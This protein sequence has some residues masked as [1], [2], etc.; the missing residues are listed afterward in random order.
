M[1]YIEPY[2]TVYQISKHIRCNLSG[3]CGVFAS[4]CSRVLLKRG[5]D[6]FTV[7]FGWVKDKEGKT[8]DHIWLEVNGEELDPTIVQFGRNVQY[9]KQRKHY[10]PKNFLR[11][12]G[13][14]L[15]EEKT[16]PWYRSYIN[17]RMDGEVPS[18]NRTGH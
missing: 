1:K 17:T 8:F 14:S 5:F 12:S 18:L 7:V 11:K 3:S 9:L 2:N 6:N 10:S 15:K 13:F 4:W 16:I